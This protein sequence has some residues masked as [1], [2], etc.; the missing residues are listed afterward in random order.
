MIWIRPPGR[1]GHQG[2]RVLLSYALHRASPVWRVGNETPPLAGAED[3][4]HIGSLSARM[5]FIPLPY[6]KK[7]SPS[8]RFVWNFTERTG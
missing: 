2:S 4:L 5:L 8:L 7:F 3:P 6:S 1:G